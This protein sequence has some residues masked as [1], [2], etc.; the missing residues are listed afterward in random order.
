MK[1]RITFLLLFSFLTANL[2]FSQDKIEFDYSK[3]YES[4]LKQTKDEGSKI[5][6]DDL[7]KRFEE[8][9]SS[10]TSYEMIA[11]QIGYTDHPNYWPYQDIDL[12]REV[13]SLNE[14]KEFDKAKSKLDTLLSNNPFSILGHRE[15]SYVYSKLGDKS[16]ADLHIRKF[17]LVVTSVLSTGDGTSYENSWFTLSPADGQW[18]IKLAFRQGI[19]SMGSGRDEDGNFHDILG[20]QFKDSEDCPKLFFN[21]EPASSR[22]FGPEGLQLD[23]VEEVDSDNTENFKGKKSPKEKKKN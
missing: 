23:G 1:H 5:F 21:I 22:M 19:C 11:L 20:I 18:I 15:M 2:A 3:D 12:E 13:W 9:D 14:E 16:K 17:D 10:L 7:F 8:A 4:I 6:Y